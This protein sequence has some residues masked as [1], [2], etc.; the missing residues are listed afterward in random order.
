VSTPLEDYA[1]IGDCETVALVSRRGS[2]DWLC[3]P[4]FDSGACFAGLLGTAEHGRWLVEAVD[5]DAQ[6]T[7]RYRPNTLIL[8]TTIETGSGTV[9][10]IDFMPLRGRNSDVV[11]LVRGD[12]GRVEMRT[13]LVLRFDYGSTVPWVSRLP[14]GTFRAIAGPDMVVMHT[15]VAL[16]GEN[17]TTVGTFHVEA[18]STVPLVL[19]HGPSHLPPPD[20]IDVEASLAETEDFW[21]D[22]AARNQTRGEWSDAVTRSLITLK[23]LTYA[24]TG[25]M[26]AAPTTSL[27]EKLGGVRNW[28]YRFCW[29]RDATLTLLALMNAGYYDEAQAWRDWL[30]RAAAGSPSQLQIMYGLAGERRLSEYEV[31]WLPGYEQS[32]PVR[33]GNAAHGQLQLDVY[34]EVVDTLFQGKR[35]GLETRPADWNFLRAILEHLEQ[36]W[37]RPDKGVWETRGDPQHFTFSKIMSWV[38]LD[39]GIRAIEGNKVEGP[40]A[41]WREVRQRIHAEVCARGFNSEIG[42]FVQSYDSKNLDASLLLIPTTGF[43]PADDP[44]IR[45]TIE[46]VERHLFVDGFVRRYDTHTTDDGLPPGEGAF[47][48][49]SFWLVDALLLS[50]RQDDARQLFERLLG[51]RNDVGLLAEEYDT[52]A[53]RLV[54]NFPQ[55]FS[56]IALVNSAHNLGHAVKPAQQR[57]ARDNG[58]R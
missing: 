54:G 38:A 28:D 7:R 31:P 10:V 40:V 51:L 22:W 41:R 48:A 25:G 15:P 43:L 12:R 16:H 8:E 20:P 13:E 57:S 53:K 4:R 50:G 42:S 37:S 1:I 36:V 47:L 29:L 56:H 32:T 21:V 39:R 14:D 2:I 33:I 11:R 18:G 23:A 55:A 26:V 49:C 52:G 34:G 19:T 3:W 58:G 30:L 5:A 9:I 46:A 17:L 27:P 44:R 45:G 6:V 35:G 24:P